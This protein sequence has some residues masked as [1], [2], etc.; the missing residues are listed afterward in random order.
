MRET[1]AVAQIFSTS[2]SVSGTYNINSSTFSNNIG[3]QRSRWRDYRAE[4]T[5]DS[6]HQFSDGQHGRYQWWRSL[7]QRQRLG[8]LFKT[9]RQQRS[10][11][12]EWTDSVRRR[13]SLLPRMIT[14]GEL[15]LVQEQ[16]IFVTSPAPCFR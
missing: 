9:G 3:A 4:R 5:T 13:R 7:F 12:F 2:T 11:S 14:G 6:H 10:E 15:T 8:S 1:V 16:M